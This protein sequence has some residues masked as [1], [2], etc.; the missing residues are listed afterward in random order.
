MEVVHRYGSHWYFL[1]RATGQWPLS[2]FVRD[3]IEAHVS[4]QK[5]DFPPRPS[6]TGFIQR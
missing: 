5:A 6:Q 2:S 4:H 3:L 1:Y